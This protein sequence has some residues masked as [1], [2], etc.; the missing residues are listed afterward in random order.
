MSRPSRTTIDERIALDEGHPTD[1]VHIAQNYSNKP[2]YHDDPECSH[3]KGSQTLRE[4]SREEAQ[5][6]GQ[7][8]CLTCVLGAVHYSDRDYGGPECPYCGERVSTLPSHLRS[9][10]CGS[11]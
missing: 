10:E 3:V 9:T 2:R 11:L 4:V 1:T 5:S 7:P 8:P 6:W